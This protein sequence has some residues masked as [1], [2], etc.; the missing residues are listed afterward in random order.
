[1]KTFTLNFYCTYSCVCS[2]KMHL[3]MERPC[4]ECPI[5]VVHQVYQV[6]IRTRALLLWVLGLESRPFGHYTVLLSCSEY[7]FTILIFLSSAVFKTWQFFQLSYI[8]QF[9]VTPLSKSTT[10][11]VL[12]IAPFCTNCYNHRSICCWSLLISNNFEILR[13]KSKCGCFTT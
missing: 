8:L 3:K 11:T 9:S 12:S 6:S 2:L 5:L 10:K 13:H 7:T 1:M 4:T